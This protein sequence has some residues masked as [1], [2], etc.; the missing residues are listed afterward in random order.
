MSNMIRKSP[1]AALAP[2]R[3]AANRLK[4]DAMGL[5]HVDHERGIFVAD[6]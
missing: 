2:D 3:M 6:G 1:G 5:V 4:I